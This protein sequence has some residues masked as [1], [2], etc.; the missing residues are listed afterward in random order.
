LTTN[1]ATVSSSV[2]N[3]VR[4]QRHEQ[5]RRLFELP[6]LVMSI[7]FIVVIV[8]P[9]A[10]PHVGGRTRTA[11][12][13]ANYGLWAAFAVEYGALVITAPARRRYVLTHLPDLLLVA[14]PLLRPL[15]FLRVLRLG[16]AATATAS[17]AR[18]RLLERVPL[19]AAGVAGLA[20][21]SASVMVLSAERDASGSN[22]RNFGDAVWWSCTTITTVGYGDH[23]PVT[24][25]GRAIAVVLMITGIALLGVVTAAVAAWLIRTDTSDDQDSVALLR[26]LRQELAGLRADVATL[27]TNR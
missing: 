19:Y 17:R 27:Q 7:A 11:L 4:E 25:A 20:V 8:W 2:S 24:A 14:L 3:T 12:D 9:L 13:V 6:M 5:V 18:S 15:R 26:E 23:F 1:D 22:I 16:A 21:V 10:D